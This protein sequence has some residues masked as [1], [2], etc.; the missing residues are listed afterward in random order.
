MNV[1]TIIERQSPIG[2]HRSIHPI[3]KAQHGDSSGMAWRLACCATEKPMN[4]YNH[5]AI[6]KAQLLRRLSARLFA[7]VC[8]FVAVDDYAAE[9]IIA[10]AVDLQLG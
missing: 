1:G 8:S 10:Q 9:S 6:D 3:V 5:Y 2:F 7:R 4:N